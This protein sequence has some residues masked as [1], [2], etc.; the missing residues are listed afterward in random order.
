MSVLSEEAVTSQPPRRGR[1]LL[2]A[3]G[4]TVALAL[5]AVLALYVFLDGGASPVPAEAPAA[6]PAQADTS[7]EPDAA[8][9]PSA[10]DALPVVTY[11]VYLSRD[12]FE[13]VVPEPEPE[14]TPDA[15]ADPAD[16]APAPPPTA[17][18]DPEPVPGTPAPA[19]GT[20]PTAPPSSPGTGDPSAPPP[21]GQPAPTPPSGKEPSQPT[22]L[23]ISSRHD[24]TPVAIIQLRTTTYEVAAGETFADSYRLVEF[25]GGGC[26]NILYGDV[27]QA[28]CVGGS[29]K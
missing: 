5:G 29:P 19:P 28:Y 21:S 10:I 12:P 24:G 27:M 16:P 3:G 1:T 13:P 11:E 17:P 8:E 4:I 2:L 7:D 20:D 22:V 6:M 9:E 25:L 14:P 23:E 18:T 26:V 15:D